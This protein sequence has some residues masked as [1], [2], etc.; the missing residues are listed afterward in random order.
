M[1][2]RIILASA[3]VARND[4]LRSAGVLFESRPARIDEPA[5]RAAL[6]S[7]NAAPR[8]VADALA[9][10]KARRVAERDP[11][12]LVIGCDQVLELRGGIL[13]KPETS[14]AAD[15]QLGMLAGQTHQLHSAAVIYENA[16]PVW[17]H[18]STARLTMRPL[19]DEYRASYVA[20]NW[21]TIRHTVGGYLLEREGVRLFSAVEGDYFTVLGLPLTEILNYLVLRQA[22]AS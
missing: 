14:E 15:A 22:V 18:I 13:G 12:A 7:E 19:S 11:G 16:A 20:R 3:S 6:T 17:R 10:F 9:E 8:D 21:D 1:T 4:L 2:V 5:L